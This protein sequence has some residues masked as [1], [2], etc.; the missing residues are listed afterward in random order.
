MDVLD[1]ELGIA[2][3]AITTIHSAMNDQPVIDSHHLD[4]RKTRSALTSIIPV[5]T[6][7]EKGIARILPRMKGKFETLTLRVPT[8]NVSLMDIT[9]TVEK[10]TTSKQVN[11]A[12]IRASQGR[13]S[14]I[15]GVSEEQLVS[16]DF[17]HDP[18]SCVVDLVQTRVSANR[19]V[20][21]QAWFDNEWGFANRM[22]DTTLAAL[23]V[24]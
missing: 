12:L 18:H 11:L 15:L 1:R 9:L 24:R 8:P 22:L 7:L 23:A 3:G 19:L 14:G 10:N 17:N 4:L 5:A 13:L 20:K 2:N 16:C 6:S 21:I